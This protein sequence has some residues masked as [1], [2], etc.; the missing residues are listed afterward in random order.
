MDHKDQ[1]F[2]I[3]TFVTSSIINSFHLILLIFLLILVYPHL[4]D[5]NHKVS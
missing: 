3:V 1:D 5:E 4:Q 2:H